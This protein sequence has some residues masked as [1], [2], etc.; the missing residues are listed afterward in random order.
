MVRK[1][2]SLGFDSNRWPSVEN[3]PLNMGFSRDLSICYAKLTKSRAQPAWKH[4][5]FSPIVGDPFA[6][7]AP[8]LETKE[9]QAKQC[10]IVY[11]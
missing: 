11:G 5:K 6:R 3:Q 4:L 2:A 7:K 10:S 8:N 1:L 9:L